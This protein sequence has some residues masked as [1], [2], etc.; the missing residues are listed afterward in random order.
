MNNLGKGFLTEQHKLGLQRAQIEDVAGAKEDSQ[1]HQQHGRRRPGRGQ[2]AM[3]QGA[4]AR[5]DKEALT[6]PSA[7]GRQSAWGR[8]SHI[9]SH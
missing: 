8:G 3:R 4:E 5:P 1:S 6:F 9:W 2:G 7:D